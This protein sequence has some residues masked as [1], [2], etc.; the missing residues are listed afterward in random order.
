VIA[1]IMT[2]PGGPAWR[3]T[4]FFPF[5]QASRYGRGRVLQVDPKSPVHGTAKYGQV[6]ML[7]ATAVLDEHSGE[8]TVFAVN[9]SQTQALPLEVTLH[10]T[11]ACRVVEHSVLADPDP[12]AR[13][14][15]AEPDRVVPH[16]ATGA[17]IDGEL[18]RC[19]LQPLSWNMIRLVPGAG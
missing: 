7:H 9:R 17:T 19:E 3:Q 13:N 4:T 11:T 16:Q 14:T 1:P 6:P 5:A 10:G 8:V 15:L 18:L 12:D 2:E